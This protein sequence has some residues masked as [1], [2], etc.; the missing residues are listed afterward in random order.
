MENKEKLAK[1]LG[2][3]IDEL[4]RRIDKNKQAEEDKI[5]ANAKNN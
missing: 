4:E 5:D 3:S 1:K 2:I